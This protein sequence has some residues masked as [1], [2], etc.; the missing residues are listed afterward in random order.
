MNGFEYKDNMLHCEDVSL[1]EIAQKY[2]TPTYVYSYH[3][4]ING[5]KEIDKAFSDIEHLICYSVKSN[6]NMGIIRALA[7]EG[8]GADVV[9]VG[10]L[11]CSLKA[12]IPPDKIIFAGVGKREDEIEYALNQ[13]IFLFN[14]E[15]LPEAYLINNVAKRLGK[16][17]TVAL[18]I[19]PDVE[20]STH[21]YITTGKK[22]NK[23]GICL[24]KAIDVIKE[25]SRLKY[26]N[27]CGLHSHIGSQ[28]VVD[29]PYIIAMNRLKDLKFA[30]DKEGV[31]SKYINMGGGF[32]IRYEEEGPLD[33]KA[34]A[35]KI[36]PMVKEME[37]KLLMEPGRFISGP[38]GVLLTKLLYFKIGLSKNFAIVDSGMTELIRPSL[39]SAYHK[40]QSVVEKTEAQKVIA[41][42][43]GPICESGDFLGKDRE[44]RMPNQGDLFTVMNG[45][46]YG[47]TM[48]SNYNSR[49]KVAEVLVKGDKCYLIRERESIEDLMKSEIIPEI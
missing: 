36:V 10:E 48:S 5:Y 16:K 18:R 49:P 40:I 23:F 11:I 13:D 34:L 22:E 17:A 21:E 7:K 47:F 39:Y 4:L 44:I 25:I 46:A 41:D 29:E 27:F 14:I 9:S 30:L 3:T 15:S 19:N 28:I 12:G 24:D 31:E 1:I 38:S 42:F 26:L 45:G 2:G 35:Q 37:C 8:A 43:V 33:I 20:A 6:S 32:G